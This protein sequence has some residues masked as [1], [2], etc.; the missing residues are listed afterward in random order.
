MIDSDIQALPPLHHAEPHPESLSL[1]FFTSNDHCDTI[2]T[3]VTC[4]VILFFT[5]TPLQAEASRT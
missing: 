5:R 1:H 4:L 2:Q 3:I